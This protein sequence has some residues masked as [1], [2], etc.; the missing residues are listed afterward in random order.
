MIIEIKEDKNK[1]GQ[2]QILEEKF[3]SNKGN[4][5]KNTE[6]VNESTQK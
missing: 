5:I 3:A 1:I 2:G 4:S 6:D